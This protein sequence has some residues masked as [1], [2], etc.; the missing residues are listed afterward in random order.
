MKN[1]KG[2]N[3]QQKVQHA[4]EG[5]NPKRVAKLFVC[6]MKIRVHQNKYEPKVKRS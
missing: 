3:K 6:P 5:G 4:R 2:C 1:K